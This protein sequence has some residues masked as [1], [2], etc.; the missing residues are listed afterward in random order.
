[1]FPI[2][3]IQNKLTLMLKK[4]YMQYINPIFDFPDL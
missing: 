4:I 3:I 2:I 1:M